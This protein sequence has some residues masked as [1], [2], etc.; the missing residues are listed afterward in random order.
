MLSY[1][2]WS[3]IVLTAALNAGQPVDRVALSLTREYGRALYRD[4]RLNITIYEG[5][6]RANWNCT[7]NIEP[8]KIVRAE[9]ALTR[10][11]VAVY[12]SL[13][14]SS[15]LCSGG[16]TGLDGREGDG[17]LETLMTRC[18]DGRVAVLVTSGNPTFDA[19]KSR[20]QL[21]DRLYSLEQE[22]RKSAAPPKS[23]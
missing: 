16:A 3:A 19:N 4:C 8:V 6:G 1:L 12:F 20:R 11:E 5:Q 9:R 22:L 13:S 23:P 18:S 10:Q 21:L 7:L 15:D 2:M 14:R 17:M